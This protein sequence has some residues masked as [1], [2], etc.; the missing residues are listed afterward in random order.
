MAAPW[1]SEKALKQFLGEIAKIGTAVLAGE[2]LDLDKVWREVAGRMDRLDASVGQLRDEGQSEP[3]QAWWYMA[4]AA[5]T[6]GVG[7]LALRASW[8]ASDG[9]QRVAQLEQEMRSEWRG[10]HVGP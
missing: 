1:I 2:L 4:G 5:A 3:A 8:Q 7:V 10:R 9:A 6:V